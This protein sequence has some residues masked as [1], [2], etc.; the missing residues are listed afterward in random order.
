MSNINKKWLGTFITMKK[1][2]GTKRTKIQKK[3]LVLFNLK[4]VE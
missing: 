1:V 3:K 4:E 2:D